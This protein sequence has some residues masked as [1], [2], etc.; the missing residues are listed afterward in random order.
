MA[1]GWIFEVKRGRD[2][3]TSKVFNLGRGKKIKW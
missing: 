2:T 1:A 3:D